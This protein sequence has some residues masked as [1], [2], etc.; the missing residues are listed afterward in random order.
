M[1]S[2]ILVVH[3]TLLKSIILKYNV[4]TR[5]PFLGYVTYIT[6]NN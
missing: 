1:H 2:I 3:Y 6:Y 5:I 4:N